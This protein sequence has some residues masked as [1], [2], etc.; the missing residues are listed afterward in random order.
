MYSDDKFFCFQI[1]GKFNN[2]EVYV[3]LVT[4][5]DKS[6]DITRNLHI[7]CGADSSQNEADVAVRKASDLSSFLE[8]GCVCVREEQG[9]ESKR[10]LDYFKSVGGLKL[11][12]RSKIPKRDSETKNSQN[13]NAVRSGLWT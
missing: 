10:F 13:S 7:W 12:S 5:V 2:D 9:G 11:V 3:V 4:V 1:N 8:S 6:G